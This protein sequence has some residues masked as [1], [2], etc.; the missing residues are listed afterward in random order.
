MKG[1]GTGLI[2]IGLLLLC[3]SFLM[4]NT[5]TTPQTEYLASIGQSITTGS[6]DVFNL[7]KA[8]LQIMVLQAG[9]ALFI[10]GAV[11]HGF[12]SMATRGYAEG[13]A[14]PQAPHVSESDNDAE[15]NSASEKPRHLTG[16]APRVETEEEASK[17]KTATVYLW[18]GLAVVLLALFAFI[19]AQ[20]SSSSANGPAQMQV[21]TVDSLVANLEAEADRLEAQAK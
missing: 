14:V 1:I 9:G 8:Q 3:V 7:A 19:A 11:L 16:Y 20:G 10:G 18:V 15:V 6:A 5:V 2:A 21:N 4:P 13:V 12:G 17:R